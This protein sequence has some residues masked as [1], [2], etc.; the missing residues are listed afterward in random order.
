MR[1]DGPSF[2]DE[3][4]HLIHYFATERLGANRMWFYLSVLVA[5]VGAALYGV[6]QH[7]YIALTVAFFGLLALV[8]WYISEE[9][10]WTKH[11]RVICEKLARSSIVSPRKKSD[12]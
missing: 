8:L 10:R 9:R 12:A 3:E 7:D 11:Y 2:T 1:E 6:I 5:P 4:S